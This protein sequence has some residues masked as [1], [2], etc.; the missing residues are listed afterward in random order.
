[1]EIDYVPRR[2]K[3]PQNP[4]GEEIV[5]SME[6]SQ[7]PR[8]LEQLGQLCSIIRIVETNSIRSKSSFIQTNR[9]NLSH[10]APT[11]DSNIVTKKIALYL[12]AG[13]SDVINAINL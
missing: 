12:Q 13:R 2:S 9:I 10:G 4:I 5:L 11:I 6:T 3:L 8:Y 1:M 7:V